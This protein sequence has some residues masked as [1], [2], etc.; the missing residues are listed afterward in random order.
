MMPKFASGFWQCKLRY[1]TQAE[2]L[3]VAHEY[4]DRGLPINVIVI[5]IDFFHWPN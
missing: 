3:K 5:V 2:L 4:K 1:K